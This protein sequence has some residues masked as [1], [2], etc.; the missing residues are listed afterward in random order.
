MNNE[1]MDGTGNIEI[2]KYRKYGIF[3]LKNSFLKRFVEKG[4]M[5]TALTFSDDRL[6]IRK[7]C[8][9]ERL[10]EENGHFVSPCQD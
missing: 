8:L 4:V 10:L 7:F 1:Q 9:L 6:A 3:I 2:G 5:S